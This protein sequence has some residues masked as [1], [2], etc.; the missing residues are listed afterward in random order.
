MDEPFNGVDVSTQ[1]TTLQLLHELKQQQVTV[2]VSTHDL[3]MA[4][5]R[6][7][8]VLLLNHRLVAF[9]TPAEVFTP[10]HISEAFGAHVLYI[11]G[12]VIVDD[13]CPHDLD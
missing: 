3:N 12:A 1:E 7:E 9:G 2:M 13:C 11:E 10:Q 8:L 5:E 4:A 6:F